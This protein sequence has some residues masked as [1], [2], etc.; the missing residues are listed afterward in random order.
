MTRRHVDHD[1]AGQT[2]YLAEPDKG[3]NREWGT[4]AEAQADIERRAAFEGNVS[5]ISYGFDPAMDHE[6]VQWVDVTY[7]LDWYCAGWLNADGWSW[8]Q[9]ADFHGS[10]SRSSYYL[11]AD[12]DHGGARWVSWT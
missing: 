11:D 9:R 6:E 7:D 3:P 12:L 5:K 1:K 10:V 4:L 2:F 8:E